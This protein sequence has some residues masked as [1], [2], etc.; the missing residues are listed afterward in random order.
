MDNYEKLMAI[1]GVEN[2]HPKLIGVLD[3][4]RVFVAEVVDEVVY[5]TDD[6]KKLLAS[7]DTV[8][9]AEKPAKRSKKT[10]EVVKSTNELAHETDDLNLSE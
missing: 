2:C 1:P 7:S 10:T 6:G 3:G 8:V 4:K 9:P 5:L